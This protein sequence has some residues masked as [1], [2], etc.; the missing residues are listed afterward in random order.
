M[1]PGSFAFLVVLALLVPSL[2]AAQQPHPY[3][4][5][6]TVD[7]VI[8]GD[9]NGMKIGNGYR[10][11]IRDHSNAPLQ[12]VF[13]TVNFQQGVF[14]YANQPAPTSLDCM[15]RIIGQTTDV[16]GLVTFVP[17]IG[18]Y[19]NAPVMAIKADDMFIT[20]ISG[21]STDLNAN[22]ATDAFDLAHF[23][24][25]FLSNPNAVETDYDRSGSTDVNDFNIFRQVFLNDIPGSVCN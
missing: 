12:G 17:R 23:R 15:S 22:G 24:T 13:V 16:N 11:I 25:N 6:C 18:G 2:A 9:S 4:P 14:P 3:P 5:N 10:V 8:V 21:R 7:P 19:Q 20:Q 1:R